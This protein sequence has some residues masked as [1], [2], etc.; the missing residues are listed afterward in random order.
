MA[1]KAK[2]EKKKLF[3]GKFWQ[4]LK[5]KAPQVLGEVAGVAGD[6]TGIE[7]LKKAGDLISGNKEIDPATKAELLE[8]QAIEREELELINADRDSARR[9]E[10]AFVQA[11]GRDWF[12]YVVG[13]VVLAVNIFMVYFTFT[14][15]LPNP[16]V[17]HF[18]MGEMVGLFIAVVAYYYGT[19]RGSK[20]KQ[21]QLDKVMNR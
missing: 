3:Q 19:S 13:A 1:G 16:K 8:L 4:T 18:L 6:L 20:H 9:R 21:E 10:T 11:V 17:A 12:M 14:R 5:E 7:L 2:R 15:E